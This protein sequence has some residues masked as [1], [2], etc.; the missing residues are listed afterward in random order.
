MSWDWHRG[1]VPENVLVDDTAYIETTYSFL[2]FRSEERSAITYG[3]GSATY[4][5]TMFDLGQQGKVRLGQYVLVHGARFICD[6]RI[7]IGDYCLI[8]WG[9]LFMDS[10]RLP[11]DP[12]RRR[13]ELRKV[14]SRN[15]R[16]VECVDSPRPIRINSNVWVGFG[17][18]VLPGVTIGEGSIIGAR[19]VVIEDVPPYSMAVGNPARIVRTLDR[20]ERE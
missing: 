6:D 20:K 10:Y 2:L 1:R 12:E 11:L 16:V 8:S 17:A 15:P 9:V 7:D 18:C 3:R 5:G 14:P 4:R 19:S 13:E